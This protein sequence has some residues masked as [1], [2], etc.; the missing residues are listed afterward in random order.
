[1]KKREKNN[2]KKKKNEKEKEAERNLK[3][4]GKR[5]RK[6]NKN[7]NK[8]KNKEEEEDE[9]RKSLKYSSFLQI[10]LTLTS[11]FY[12][13]TGF[14]LTDA[15]AQKASVFFQQASIIL[16]SCLQQVLH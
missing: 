14:I 11:K 5:R 3:R 13:S 1:M 2:T 15:P 6:K 7:K 9:E 4:E 12:N 8:N 16:V 10:F